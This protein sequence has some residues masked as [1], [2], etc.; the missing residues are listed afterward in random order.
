MAIKNFDKSQVIE[1][2][3][4]IQDALA[5]VEVDYGIKIDTGNASYSDNE[6][7][8]K[9]KANTVDSEGVT[10][11]T[12]ASNWNRIAPKYGLGDLKAGD[13]VTL[14]GK[15]YTITGWNL[16]ARKSPIGLQDNNGKIFKAPLSILN[17]YKN[18]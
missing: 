4:A 16:R 7:S 2:R 11:T 13:Q 14:Q 9:V 5:Q 15:S 18:N 6:V 1:L 3:K 12:E 10:Q 8:F 17:G